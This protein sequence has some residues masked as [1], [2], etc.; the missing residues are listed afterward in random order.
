MMNS[1]SLASLLQLGLVLVLL[2]GIIV[3]WVLLSKYF[4][5]DGFPGNGFLISN[6]LIIEARTPG[7]ESYLDTNKHYP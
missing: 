7:V 2:L 5:K 1:E 3:F 6:Q 4:F